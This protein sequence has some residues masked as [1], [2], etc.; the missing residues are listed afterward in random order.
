MPDYDVYTLDGLNNAIELADIYYKEGFVDVEAKSGMHPETYKV[1]VNF[2]P[3]ADLTNML[4][5]VFNN[6][7]RSQ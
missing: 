4:K 1:Y 6:I 2:I 7:K 3:V 5:E